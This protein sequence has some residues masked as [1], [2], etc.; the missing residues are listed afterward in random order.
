MKSMPLLQRLAIAGVLMSATVLVDFTASAR[1]LLSF[2][3]TFRDGDVASTAIPNDAIIAAADAVTDD[4]VFGDEFFAYKI[5]AEVLSLA[6][7]LN[8]AVSEDASVIIGVENQDTSG[9]NGIDY[10][11]TI[12]RKCAFVHIH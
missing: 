12:I 2:G 1:V 9:A 10:D 8:L 3:A 5:D 11:K 4:P 6:V 7:D